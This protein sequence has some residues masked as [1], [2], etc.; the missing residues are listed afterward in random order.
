MTNLRR[1]VD[2]FLGLSIGLGLAGSLSD[3]N[4]LW[5]ALAALVAALVCMLFVRRAEPASSTS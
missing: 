1:S 5:T 2:T 3:D 4:R